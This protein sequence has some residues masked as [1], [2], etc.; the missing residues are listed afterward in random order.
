[1][2]HLKLFG[3][4]VLLFIA[5][6]TLTACTNKDITITLAP[7]GG[8]LDVSTIVFK[9]GDNFQ[10]PTPTRDGYEF[11]GWFIDES[12]NILIS[13]DTDFTENSTLFASWTE[14]NPISLWNIEYDAEGILNTHFTSWDS[15][16]PHI[17][18]NDVT[19]E[20]FEL[21][22][23]TLYQKDYNW[24]LAISEGLATEKYDF[25]NHED[26]P[27][28][29]V[30]SMAASEPVRI[31]DIIWQV[32]LNEGL[33]FS[34]GDPINALTFINSYKLLLDPIMQNTNANYLF[35]DSGLQLKNAERYYNQLTSQDSLGFQVYMNDTTTYKRE[36][37]LFGT[38]EGHPDWPLYNLPENS[39]YSSQHLVGPNGKEC[40]LENWEEY[41]E[42]NSVESTF[43]L[44][45]IDGKY[46]RIDANGT[47]YAQE[48]GW[49]LDGTELA[50]DTSE[51]DDKYV[52]GLPA[53][54]DSEG[55]YAPLNLDGYPSNA[56]PTESI[57][58][59]FN[60]VGITTID[61]YTIQFTFSE[62]ISA[63]HLK[64]ALSLYALSVV[65]DTLYIE[66]MNDANTETTYGQIGEDFY[67][68]GPYEL[69]VYT[70]DLFTFTKRSLDRYSNIYLIN[71]INMKHFANDEAIADSYQSS[72]LDMV[73]N[74][75]TEYYYDF[76]T[77]TKQIVPLSVLS[78]YTLNGDY[79][80]DNDS[81]NDNPYLEYYDFRVALYYALN[82]TQSNDMANFH[83]GFVS[84]LFMLD[85]YSSFNHRQLDVRNESISA[86]NEESR[87]SAA[88][89]KEHF[90]KAYNQMISDG[91]IIDGDE[92]SISLAYH[93]IQL[94]F[95]KET[96]YK[97]SIE[98]ILGSHFT[99]DLIGYAPNAL[100]I[101]K[102][103]YAYDMILENWNF[104]NLSS[105]DVLHYYYGVQNFEDADSEEFNISLPQV[106]ILLNQMKLKEPNLELKVECQEFLDMYTLEIFTGSFEDIFDLYQFASEHDYYN[107]ED[108][109]YVITSTLEIK[110]YDIMPRIPSGSNAKMYFYSDRVGLPSDEFNPFM[111]YGNFKYMYI[112]LED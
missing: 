41:N 66:G 56:T 64:S 3:I 70:N 57:Q 50:V 108:D 99:L 20:Y 98:D 6:C 30:P 86:F 68:F 32:T 106:R 58:M 28:I 39:P 107:T 42:L 97:T 84:E 48:A 96:Y 87:Y 45:T 69:D 14:K 95:V 59:D 63:E 7:N 18:Q 89:A 31:T 102:S 9:E 43:F 92:I 15:F 11:D 16:N 4:F 105:I 65:H 100:K 74:I 38:I 22:S 76:T 62:H 75:A 23:D 110:L 13:S 10:I 29:F 44:S 24:D 12:L 49:V 94:G 25:S 81:L 103:T 26:L 35:S 112:V 73:S 17:V 2:K 60:D 19:L 51:N 54:M 91:L 5:T 21:L 78:S 93:D 1:M 80:H 104:S 47:M 72:N 34:N 53:Y 82:T 27:Q 88:L 85:Q 79:L 40:Y 33:S 67:S 109:L 37:S 90:N 77:M 8:T 111:N 52:G 36:Y 83:D 71:E 61:E 101:V 46:F 55:N